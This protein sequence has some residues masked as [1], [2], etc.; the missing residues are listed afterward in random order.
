LE[1]PD[2]VGEYWL[3]FYETG[4][5][6]FGGSAYPYPNY[7]FG[8]FPQS[9]RLEA[10]VWTYCLVA[11]DGD[12]NCRFVLWQEGRADVQGYYARKLMGDGDMARMAAAGELPDWRLSV[13][14]YAGETVQIS[15]CTVLRFEELI[16]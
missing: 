13:K 5:P 2:L 15:D 10:N 8:E 6:M 12:G 9:F 11:F 3:Q 4:Y 1:C 16:Q 14:L 7:C